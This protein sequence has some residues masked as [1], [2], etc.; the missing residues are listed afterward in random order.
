MVREALPRPAE[1][2]SSP[3]AGLVLVVDDEPLLLRALA[4]ILQPDG[5][6]VLLAER[7]DEVAAAL[8]EPGLDAV[9]LDLR[10]GPHDGRDLL[11]RVK[12]E[13]PEVEVI[14]MTGHAS[15]ESA[16]DCMRAG[17]FDYLEKPLPE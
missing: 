1:L 12:R 6:R 13:R 8:V 3:S 15:V 4:R 7:V 11:A 14:M 10:L 2:V 9:L 17:A 16:V 5:H